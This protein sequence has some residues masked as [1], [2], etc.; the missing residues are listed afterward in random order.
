MEEQVTQEKTKKTARTTKT[1]RAAKTATAEKP[2]TATV[3]TEQ[4]V[5]EKLIA[6]PRMQREQRPMRMNNR[7]QRSFNNNF[8]N[9]IIII[10]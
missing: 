5:T 1:T 10:G 6:A 9:K 3:A 2:E 7:P 4:P 8:N